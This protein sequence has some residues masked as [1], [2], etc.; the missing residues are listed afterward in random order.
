MPRITARNVSDTIDLISRD[1]QKSRAVLA[2]SAC[3]RN[4]KKAIGLPSESHARISAI[5]VV[6]SGCKSTDHFALGHRVNYCWS[7][8][9]SANGLRFCRPCASTSSFADE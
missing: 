6:P 4:R 7:L 8:L 2:Y 1:R 3:R 9:G 5:G